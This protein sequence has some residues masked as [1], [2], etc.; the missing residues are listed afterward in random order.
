MRFVYIEVLALVV[1]CD[2]HCG[3]GYGMPPMYVAACVVMTIEGAMDGVYT[4]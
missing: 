2:C 4:L 1:V 3:C